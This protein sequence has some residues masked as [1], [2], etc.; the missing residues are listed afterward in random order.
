M[1]SWLLF[2]FIYIC[3]LSSSW[4]KPSHWVTFLTQCLSLSIFGPKLGQN[5]Q[6]FFRV[7]ETVNTYHLYI[8]LKSTAVMM[9]Y[10]S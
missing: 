8:K 2:L 3:I 5:N 7:F 4:D 1:P 10:L 9:T 6:A